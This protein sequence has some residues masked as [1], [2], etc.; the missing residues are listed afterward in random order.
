MRILVA[1]A[2]A[3]ALLIVAAPAR[4]HIAEVTT[5]VALEEVADSASLQ[6]VLRSA[7]DDARNRT[8]AFEPTVIAVTDARVLGERIYFRLLFA[9][10]DGER[11]LDELSATRRT[12]PEPERSFAPTEVAYP[13]KPI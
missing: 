12:E 11:T 7:V 6:D 13:K 10:A 9:D 2:L 3:L 5:S 1:A 8:I 4:A